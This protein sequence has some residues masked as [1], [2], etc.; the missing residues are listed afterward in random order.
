MNGSGLACAAHIR[1]VQEGESTNRARVGCAECNGISLLTV[2]V[3]ESASPLLEARGTIS[4]L[5]VICASV[6]ET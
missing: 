3:A 6:Y 1:L 4:Q 5:E 2:I